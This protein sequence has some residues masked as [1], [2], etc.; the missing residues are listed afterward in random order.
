MEIIPYEG[1]GPLRF[2]MSKSEVR[3]ALGAPFR[4]FKKTLEAPATSDAF[5]TMGVYVYYKPTGAC[6]AVEVASPS[7]ATLFGKQLVGEIFEV[8]QK[9]FRELDPEV[10]MDDAGMTSLRFGVGIY[11]PRLKEG[12]SVPVEGAIAFERGY[13]G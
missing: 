6:E 1:I 2:G 3:A 11:A 13:Y 7:Q 12:S 5:H 8:L 4:E 9:W 10:E